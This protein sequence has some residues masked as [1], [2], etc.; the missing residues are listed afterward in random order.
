M[1]T[2]K[3]YGF[4]FGR[5]ECNLM[6]DVSY[7]A[8]PWRDFHITEEKSPSKRKK[9]IKEFMLEQKGYYEVVSSITKLILAYATFFPNENV[10]VGICCSAGEYRSPS[11]VESVAELL[12][13]AGVES[14]I[15]HSKNSKL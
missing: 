12:E 10:Q 1:V 5:P 4:K 13:V 11:V 2:L 15:E 14:I 3:S 9:L 7:F 8:N 6:F